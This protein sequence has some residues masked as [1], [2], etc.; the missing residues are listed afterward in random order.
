[1]MRC[2]LRLEALLLEDEEMH[3][4]L[5][6]ERAAQWRKDTARP[7]E[8]VENAQKELDRVQGEI[9]R[10][11][12]ALAS[13]VKSAAVLGEITKREVQA[14][15][16]KLKLTE[17]PVFN[18]TRQE[19]HEGLVSI[20]TLRNGTRIIDDPSKD[21]IV[22]EYAPIGPLTTG[23]VQEVRA[24]LRRLQI[25]RVTVIPQ[26]D[27]TWRFEGTANLAG[28][29]SGQGRDSGAPPDTPH[30][31]RSTVS[32]SKIV[33]PAK[34][35][36]DA[37][38]PRSHTIATCTTWLSATSAEPFE[39]FSRNSTSEPAPTPRLTDPSASAADF[40]RSVT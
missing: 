10:L 23:S 7:A 1:M 11:V 26:G 28:L 12:A 22:F 15:A 25:E 31:V 29:F 13:G 38:A 37:A 39:R 6:T 19:L 33:A 16:L 30:R 24:I 20:R 35:A 36:L 14:E 18:P 3:W 5:I 32:T 34:P 40:K 2:G 9:E 17:A 21:Y 27:G 4:Q 8:L